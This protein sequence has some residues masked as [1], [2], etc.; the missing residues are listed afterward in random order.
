MTSYRVKTGTDVVIGSLTVL[1]PQPDPGTG[2]QTTQRTYAAD[3]SVV[4]QGRYVEF[5]WSAYES[6]AT[7]VTLLALFGL[8][9]TTSTAAVTIYVRNEIYAWVRMNGTAVRPI[10]GESVK[11][12][13]VQNRPL[14]ITILVKNLTTAA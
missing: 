11:W 12:G 8:N 9:A 1:S 7:Y 14:D 2:I 6:Q 4:D 10:P 5:K 3:N 13:D